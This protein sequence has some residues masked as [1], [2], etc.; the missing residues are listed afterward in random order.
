MKFFYG[1]P[2]YAAGENN[3][4]IVDS[5]LERYMAALQETGSNLLTRPEKHV[6]KHFNG[7]QQEF[8]EALHSKPSLLR[9]Y[10]RLL[11]LADPEIA[12]ADEIKI[13]GTVFLTP[14]ITFTDYSK[15][16]NKK[17]NRLDMDE[18]SEPINTTSGDKENPDEW[19]GNIRKRNTPIIHSIEQM[20]K[21]R[22]LAKKV[23]VLKRRE[24][25]A[26]FLEGKLNSVLF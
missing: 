6:L 24:Q 17:P 1:L 16:D 12:Q 21:R 8:G 3:S 22:D 5:G 26:G 18:Y 14:E 15:F 19:T 20:K 13:A 10:I 23:D 4:W 11:A 7:I 2:V 25:P 9:A